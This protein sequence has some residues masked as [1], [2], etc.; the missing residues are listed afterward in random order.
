MADPLRSKEGMA[1]EVLHILGSAQPEGSSIARMVCTLARGI[2]P[3]RYQLRALFL[4]GEGPLLGALERVGVQCS[5]LTW[6]RGARDPAG[7]WKFWRRL[8]SLRVDLVHVHFGGRSVR[9]LARAATRGKIIMHLHSR[10]ME[11]RGPLPVQISVPDADAVVAASHAVARCVVDGCPHVIYAGAD[12]NTPTPSRDAADSELVLG[13]AGRLIPL[14]GIDHLLCAAAALQAEFPQL[15][16]EIAGSGSERANLEA[17]V[18]RLGLSGRVKFLGWVDEIR[19]ALLRWDVFVLPSLEEGFPIAALEAMAAGLPVVASSVGGVPELV[20]DGNTGWLVPPA[21]V[22]PLTSRLRTLLRD[23]E[24]R[25]K[26]GAAGRNRVREQFSLN[27]MTQGFSQL[28]D[29]LLGN[30]VT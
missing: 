21:G 18:A 1:R 5:A 12:T 10:I 26:M 19:S 13:V 4:E 9:R 23:P 15:R 29:E 28:Y 25:R 20:V 14:K 22:E 2:D 17:S 7:A 30:A 24:Q 6:W 8:R 16:I 3:A 11:S 27:L